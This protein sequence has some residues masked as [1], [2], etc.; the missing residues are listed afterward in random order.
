M[1]ADPEQVKYKKQDVHFP[2]GWGVLA[3][4]AP[5]HEG[6]K[7][8]LGSQRGAVFGGFR[9][10]GFILFRTCVGF[11]MSGCP[12]RLAVAAVVVIVAAVVV[13]AAAYVNPNSKSQN[14]NINPKPP[15]PNS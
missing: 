3:P 7:S 4:T 2:Q 12:L 10:S 11:R 8:G 14:S 9:A 15:T 6:D 13:L 1:H 5:G